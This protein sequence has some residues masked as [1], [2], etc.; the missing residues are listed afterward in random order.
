MESAFYGLN[1]KTALVTG[2][3]RG[4]GKA[5]A[6]QLARAG[7]TVLFHGSAPGAKLDAA[8]A[9]A[10]GKALAV[11]ADFCDL[12]AVE[13]LAQELI[14]KALVPEILVLNA[15]VQS[16]TGLGN[17]DPAEYLRMFNANVESSCILLHLL[18]PEMRKKKWGRVIFTGSV[19]GVKPASRLA[20]YGSTKA[21][22]MNLARTAALENA[23][24]NI[25]VNTILPGVIET[26]RN[27]K[28]LSDPE[29]AAQLREKIPM[30]RFGTAEECADLITFLASD[31]ASYITGAEIPVD[32]GLQL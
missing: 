22:L 25:T 8:V 5:A 12:Q 2:S 9:E 24:F 32:G 4:I 29:F 20:L 16:Y 10:G 14:G 21:A 26:D 17:F 18:L 3:S 23:P 1:G 15:S 7:A 13:V 28:A 19:N 27:A 6:L 31:R 11:T 30:H